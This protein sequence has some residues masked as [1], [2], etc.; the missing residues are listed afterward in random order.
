MKKV[1]TL[2]IALAMISFMACGGGKEKEK[3]KHIAD[4]TRVADSTKRVDDSLKIVQDSAD[5]QK[6][7]EEAAKNKPKGN[8]PKGGGTTTGSTGPKGK[9]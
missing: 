1:F 8:D 4:S 9:G 3:A 2:C 7:R 6:A 5:A